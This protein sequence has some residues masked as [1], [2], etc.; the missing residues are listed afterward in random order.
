MCVNTNSRGIFLHISNQRVNP[1]VL[2]AFG[3]CAMTST[4]HPSFAWIFFEMLCMMSTFVNDV[5][6]CSD[7]HLHSEKLIHFTFSMLSA[8]CQQSVLDKNLIIYN[9]SY[10]VN[11]KKKKEELNRHTIKLRCFILLDK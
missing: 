8:L 1:H 6:I 3:P 5:D 11:K 2:G 7:I 4:D 10:S 9:T